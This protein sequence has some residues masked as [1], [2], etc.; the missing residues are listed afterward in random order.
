MVGY[1]ALD[2]GAGPTTYDYSGNGHDGAISGATWDPCGVAGYALSFDGSGDYVDVANAPGLNPEEAI[3]ITAWFKADPF[4]PPGTYAW[5]SLVAKYDTGVGGGYDLSVQLIYEGTPKITT[6]VFLA[7][8]PLTLQGAEPISAES[9]YF[10]AMTYD[11]TS[12]TLYSAKTGETL[13]V[14]STSGAGG[15]VTSDSHLNIGECPYNPGRYFDGVI[16]EVAICNRSLSAEE[17]QQQYQNGLDGLGYHNPHFAGPTN[18]DYHLKSEQGRFWPEDP[19]DPNE[20]GLL[21]GLWAMDPVTSPCIDNGNPMDDPSGEGDYSGGLVN[22]GAYGG[23]AYASRSDY[24]WPLEGD[25][26]RDGIVN[27]ADFAIVSENWLDS[28]E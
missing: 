24:Y 12:L 16:D 6:S 20:F 19:T 8:G 9:W 27:L 25:V 3:T 21:D 1:W 7:G 18:D 22:M 11:G 14:V 10:T 15:L 2:K 17:I 13:S 28:I 26:N 4:P 23:T 5:P